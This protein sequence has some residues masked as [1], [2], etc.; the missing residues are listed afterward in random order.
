V[1]ELWTWLVGGVRYSPSLWTFF[2]TFRNPFP[3]PWQPVTEKN[4]A[5]CYLGEYKEENGTLHRRFFI[6][7]WWKMWLSS[8]SFH[9]QSISGLLY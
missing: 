2:N 7:S 1:A 5:R 4:F 8:I 3:T 9:R 6:W